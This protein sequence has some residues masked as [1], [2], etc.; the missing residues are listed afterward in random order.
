MAAPHA[1]A[2]KLALLA[3]M[4]RAAACRSMDRLVRVLILHQQSELQAK[5]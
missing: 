5:R 3:L 2:G 1:I 4:C